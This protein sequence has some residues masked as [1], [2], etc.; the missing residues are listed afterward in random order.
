MHRP[1]AIVLAPSRDAISG[2]ST[3]LNL[4]FASTLARDFSLIHFQVGSEGRSENAAAR[5][6]RL[7]AS[8]FALAARI[9]LADADLVHINTSLNRCAFWR[10]LAYLIVAR[11]CGAHVVYHVHGG[12]LPRAFAAQDHLPERLLRLALQLP[13]VIVVLASCELAAYCDF[14]PQQSILA[15]P[16]GI[17]V[18][19]YRRRARHVP[20]H[21]PLRLVYVGRLAERKG[22][23]ETLRGL[24]RARA[25]GVAATLAVAGSGPAE[26][27]LKALAASL[28]LADAVRFVGPVFGD[29]KP[30]LF[31]AADV[32]MLP[33]HAEGLPYALLEGMAA[34]LAVVTTRVGGIP[35]VAIEGMH[36][37]FVPIGDAD[38]IGDAI[39]RLARNR[40]M[41]ARMGTACA[42]RIAQFYTVE[43]LAGDLA[44]LYRSL[45]SARHAGA[46]S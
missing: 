39:A 37:I 30:S 5:L 43:R 9:K 27:H 2:V 8:P 13:D 41:A 22:L 31:D 4:M 10:D 35:D 18:A 17:D 11:L 32:L 24:A 28:E 3:H 1:V 36:A 16:N 44:Y 34:G 21:A 7:L 6:W 20:P 40:A 45:C 15:L 46:P 33:S 14:V 26:A 42:R 12:L 19:P 38:A 29:A 25:D 23:E